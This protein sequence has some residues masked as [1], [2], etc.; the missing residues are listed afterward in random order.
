[1]RKTVCATLVASTEKWEI[2][3]VLSP[4][5]ARAAEQ[6]RRARLLEDAV[7][8]AQEGVA[9]ELVFAADQFIITPAGRTQE[10][11]RAH[12]AATR[13]AP[14]LPVIIGSPIGAATR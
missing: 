12:A 1:M 3:E 4:A 6:Q 13:C 2:I 14:S 10:A 8:V 7:P 11:A 5:E 9:A